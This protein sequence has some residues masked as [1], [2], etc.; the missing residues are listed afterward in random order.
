[1]QI[2]A[3][4]DCDTPKFTRLP[5]G[6]TLLSL[7]FGHTESDIR[8]AGELSGIEQLDDFVRLWADADYPRRYEA[9]GQYLIISPAK[10]SDS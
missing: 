8:A 10:A 5:N 7:H 4:V 1:M 3:S 6:S 2:I 9:R